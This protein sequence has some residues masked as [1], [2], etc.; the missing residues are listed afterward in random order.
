MF[1]IMFYKLM[2]NNNRVKRQNKPKLIN[3]KI[4]TAMQIRDQFKQHTGPNSS[5][6]RASASER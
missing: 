5:V 1:L 3:D 6:V 4:L 2:P